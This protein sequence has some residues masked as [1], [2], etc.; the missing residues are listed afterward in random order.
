MDN[1]EN[2]AEVID[3]VDRAVAELITAA[4]QLGYQAGKRDRG[5]TFGQVYEETV[6]EMKDGDV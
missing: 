5:Y 6:K 2:L 3:K 4:Y 1:S